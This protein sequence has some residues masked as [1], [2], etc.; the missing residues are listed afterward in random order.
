MAQ[1]VESFDFL[2]LAGLGDDDNGK[3]NDKGQDKRVSDEAIIYDIVFDRKGHKRL[4][5]LDT[6]EYSGL[7]EYAATLIFIVDTGAWW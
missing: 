6:I 2:G 1:D 7:E 4:E 3:D 5:I